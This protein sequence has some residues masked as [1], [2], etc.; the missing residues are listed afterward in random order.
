MMSVSS[1]QPIT[2]AL[3]GQPNVGKSVIMNFLT[4]AGAIVSNYPGTTVE[5]TEGLLKTSHEEIKIIDTP[6]IY[7]LHSDTEEQRVTH[8]V[9]LEEQ[10]DL[11]VNVADASHLDRSL[12]LTLQ[13]LDLDIPLI[14]ALNQI[15]MAAE[16][17]ISIDSGK[18]SKFLGIPVIPMIATKGKGL[19]QLR[20]QLEKLEMFTPISLSKP[21]RF[22]DE[23]E[24]VIEGLTKHIAASLPENS[25]RY[26]LHPPRALAIHLLEHDRLDEDIYEKYPR[27]QAAVESFQKECAKDGY[28]CTACFRGCSFCPVGDKHP[29]LRTCLERSEYARNL[30]GSVTIKSIIPG[31]SVRTILESWID[32]P[33]T[34]IPL[35]ILVMSI[36]AVLI[37]WFL[38]GAEHAIT[39]L[40]DPLV[41]Y[42]GNLAEPIDSV[43]LKTIVQSIPDGIIIPISIVLPAMLAI[44]S[45]MALLEDT[46][47]MPRIA[48]SMD[49]L[50]SF[51]GVPGQAVIPVIL[52]FGCRVPAILATRSIPGK[53][54][55]F[56]LATLLSITIPCAATIGVMT[57]I[58]QAFNAD[59][60]IIYGTA[61]AVFLILGKILGSLVPAQDRELILEIPHLRL[62]HIE[63]IISKV[64]LR[65]SGFFS[66]VLPILVFTSIG[67]QVVLALDVL[68][69]MGSIDE[70]STQVLGLRGHSLVGV[71]VSI[72][73]RYM[74]PMVLLNLPLTPREATIAGSMI[75]VSLPC[76]PTAVV[77][78]KEYG[79]RYLL[80][81][82]AMALTICLLVGFVL[83][84]ILPM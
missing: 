70:I 50:T 26:V 28:V 11:V 2:V 27:L 72:I 42:F 15:D 7:S 10:I 73:Q 4:K 64:K 3:V 66:N 81:V 63:N 9:L 65:T 21:M 48:V 18:L 5:V 30:V 6:G 60:K 68:A 53:K 78:A 80:T 74:G 33:I 77:S 84:L 57:A 61:F 69:P 31:N 14:M 8:R 43:I 59:L 51:I 41:T 16:S 83:N 47:I 24:S 13:L 58:G 67:I 38:A 29:V 1:R 40:L 22:S 52:A 71:A 20:E 55:R 45:V 44:Y 12:Y 82:F 25:G 19:D 39:T 37:R 32:R 46:G 36:S 75:A 23:L 49:R 62:P 34:G 17:G 54:S 56:V 79:A 35:I 76:L